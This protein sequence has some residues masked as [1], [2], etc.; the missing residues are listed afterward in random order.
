MV[1]QLVLSAILIVVT[2]VTL[3]GFESTRA[4][5]TLGRRRR[6]EQLGPGSEAD[7]PSRDDPRGDRVSD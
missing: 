7:R 1:H 2:M 3:E 5:M 6:R 4:R